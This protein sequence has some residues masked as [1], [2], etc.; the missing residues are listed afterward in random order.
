M[1]GISPAT[2]VGLIVLSF[3]LLKVL[4]IGKRGLGLPPGPATLP[5][6]TFTIDIIYQSLKNNFSVGNVHM[7]PTEYPHYK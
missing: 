5:L 6:R 3:F 4:R 7:F 2:V 1:I